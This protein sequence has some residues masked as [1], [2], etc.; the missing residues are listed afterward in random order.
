MKSLSTQYKEQIIGGD[1]FDKQ[2]DE[3][4]KDRNAYNRLPLDLRNGFEDLRSYGR[5]GTKI[6]ETEDKVKE[7]SRSYENGLTSRGTFEEQ[8]SKIISRDTAGNSA[9]SRISKDAQE[10]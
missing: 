7:L 8:Y 10:H 5:N 4:I 6:T 9:Y 1:S 2:F 3:I